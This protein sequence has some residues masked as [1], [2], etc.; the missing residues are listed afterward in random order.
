MSTSL[1]G[2]K[3]T[4]FL[5]IFMRTSK[6]GKPSQ[7][8]LIS[9]FSSFIVHIVKNMRKVFVFNIFWKSNG[10][11]LLFSVIELIEINDYL[12][13]KVLICL[14]T[15]ACYC[16]KLWMYQCS[17]DQRTVPPRH[18]STAQSDEDIWKCQ[19]A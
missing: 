19:Q 13:I 11:F 3:A 17:G 12:L 14:K 2:M 5:I 15:Y 16:R 8:N 6:R 7:D 4:Y 10:L 18:Q 9:D 1:H